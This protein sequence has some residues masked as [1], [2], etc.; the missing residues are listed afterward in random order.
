MLI[1]RQSWEVFKS[2]EVAVPA[3]R[4]PATSTGEK[5]MRCLCLCATLLVLQA[6]TALA[7]GTVDRE[8]W[9]TGIRNFVPAAL[10]QDKGFF[11]SCFKVSA[12]ECH[13]LVT[14]ATESCLRQYKNQI[15]EQLVQPKDGTEWGTKVGECVG[16]I[17]EGTQA[18]K[19]IHSDKCDNCN[20]WR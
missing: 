4:L 13:I 8:K 12:D 10:C 9:V 18:A 15:P 6:T 7:G 19:R 20:A 1:Y 16:T 5:K 3:A 14:D 2:W 17:I 11:T